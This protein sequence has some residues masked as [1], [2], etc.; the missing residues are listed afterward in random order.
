MRPIMRMNRH[1]ALLIV[2][3][4]FSLL[5]LIGL[6]A[7]TATSLADQN[8]TAIPTNTPHPTRTPTI[9]STLAPTF[10]ATLAGGPIGGDTLTWTPAPSDASA[11]HEHFVMDRPIA[12]GA[13]NYP[14]RNYAYGSTD[15][16]G[17][18]VHHGDDF[19]NPTGTPVLAAADGV[20]YYAGEDVRYIFGP[21]PNFYG[22]VVVI[23]HSMSDSG[24]TVFTLYGHLSAVSVA[25]GQTVKA[26]APIGIV[27]SAGVAIGAHLHFEVR[28]ADPT[29]YNAT[30]NPELWIKPFNSYGA[31][32]GRVTDPSGLVLYG[33]SIEIQNGGLYRSAET[34]GDE[35]TPGDSLLGENFATSDLPS[36]YYSVFIKNADSGLLYRNTVF[37]RPGKVTW[38]DI[39]IAP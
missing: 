35:S 10:I 19:E 2:S 8:S 34:Y 22:R 36:G 37:V 20:I 32:A 16:G 6:I 30:R 21:Q 12:E 33:V 15:G 5:L 23:Q 26:G 24:G 7:P 18:P 1:C 3:A 38:L 9:E 17:R 11:F 13:V 31:I 27:G 29:D 25:R 28:I 4:A 14:A 39:H